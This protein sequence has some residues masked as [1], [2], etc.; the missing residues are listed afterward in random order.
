MVSQ[1]LSMG[2]RAALIKSVRRSFGEQLSSRSLP[3]AIS[4]AIFLRDKLL[5]TLREMREPSRCLCCSTSTSSV[6]C[7]T[8][9]EEL[10]HF[11]S[12]LFLPW[13]SYKHLS[14]ARCPKAL[15][16]K[17]AL[18]GSGGSC[19]LFWLLGR[20]PL[21]SFLC[22]LSG[23]WEVPPAP[24]WA[25]RALWRPLGGRCAG[26]A[27]PAGYHTSK[28]AFSGLCSSTNSF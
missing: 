8:L 16:H 23:C 18:R 3:Q 17:P 9:A 2:D 20:I 24:R 5:I 21:S 1:K 28:I 11:F 4:F 7:Q 27:G 22:L 12:H 26:E 6:A 14:Q 19:S 25:G 13:L 10:D 15:T